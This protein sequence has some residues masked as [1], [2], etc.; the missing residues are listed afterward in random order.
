MVSNPAPAAVLSLR[1]ERGEMPLHV[2]SLL[3]TYG[4]QTRP[5]LTEATFGVAP[6]LK[7]KHRMNTCLT[8]CLGKGWLRR[9]GA[10]REYCFHLTKAGRR[11][12]QGSKAPP[13]LASTPELTNLEE[14]EP[15]VS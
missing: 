1:F 3:A 15:A 2:L 13:A 8:Q 4:P 10:P 12:L 11:Q 5:A 7:Q 6:S 9:T 14:G